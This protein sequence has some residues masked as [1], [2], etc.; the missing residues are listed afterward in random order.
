MIQRFLFRL[1]MSPF[2]LLYGAGV[3]LRNIFYRFGI[4]KEVSFNLPVIAVGNLSVGGT[5]K[6][7]HVEFL[8]LWLREYIDVTILSRGYRRKTKGFLEVMAGSTAEQVGDEPLQ[9]KR[10]FSDVGVFVSESRVLGIPKILSLRPDT[11]VIILDDAFQHRSVKPGINILITDYRHLFTDDFLL[12]MGRLREWRSA[13]RRANI[14]LISKCPQ[15]ITD[16]Q[17][18]QVRE[19]INPTSR[20]ELYF[21]TYHHGMLFH[22]L[23]HGLQINF[24]S[25]MVVLILSAIANTEFLIEYIQSKVEAVKTIEYEDHHLFTSYEMAQLKIQFDAIESDNK[26]IVT[27]EK[28]AVRLEKHRRYI[29]EENMPLFVLP[30]HVSFIKEENLFKESI[31]SYLLEFRK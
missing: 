4:L 13:Y 29:E 19:S 20:Q 5:G 1:L 24:Q 15:N 25:E 22:F 23:N 30:A 10:K 26:I 8:V 17:I 9:F 14:I 12:P 2:A 16:K 11:Q 7:P 21:T 3:S 31:S 18:M 6:T 28:D 27:T